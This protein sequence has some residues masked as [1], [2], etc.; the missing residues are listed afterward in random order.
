[1]PHALDVNDNGRQPMMRRNRDVLFFALNAL[2]WSAWSV[3]Q[4]LS[5]IWYESQ[6]RPFGVFAAVAGATG[7]FLTVPMRYVCRLLWRQPPLVMLAGAVL[8]AYL[9]A[10]P[11]RVVINVVGHRLFEP[12]MAFNHWSELFLNVTL[13][14][15]LLLC[16]MGLYFGVHFY[17]ANQRA[18]ETA[19]RATG[20]AQAAQLKMLRY[21][22][23]PHFLFNTLNA[24]STLVLDGKN[25]VANT[26]VVRLADFLRYAL[27]QDPMKTVTLSQELTALNLYLEIEKLRFGAR[28]TVAIDVDR[29]AA[30]AQVPSLLLQP[31]L[32][33]SIKYA[34]SP[35]ERGGRIGIVGR[36]VNQEL[37][38]SV[39]DDGPG[40]ASNA[41][42]NRGV[43]LR[44]TRERLAAMFGERAGIELVNLHPGLRITV[45]FPATLNNTVSAE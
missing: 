7:F 42:N 16:W 6:D 17:E 27:D 8:T 39:E 15:Y 12:Q 43:G 13:S 9:L 20:L 22:L 1:M 37:E 31:L 19:L 5:I 41:D 40:I 45:R 44:N 35:S 36:V 25:A 2:G 10:L 11:M 33:N 30:E 28:L 3:A 4:Y 29:Q 32:E 34:I 24:V 38:L 26:V 18:R 14:M 21:Q 23:N